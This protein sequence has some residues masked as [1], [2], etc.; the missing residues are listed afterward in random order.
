MKNILSIVIYSIL[1]VL[2]SLPVF[3]WASIAFP[4]PESRIDRYSVLVLLLLC[5]LDYVVYLYIIKKNRFHIRW[6]FAIY[7]FDI[8]ISVISA[9]CFILMNAYMIFAMSADI[10]TLSHW[11]WCLSFLIV[12]MINIFLRR[13]CYADNKRR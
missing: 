7:V 12:L 2:I 13:K 5:I 4:V 10:K 1:H 9:V 3:I 11:L 6:A 8:I